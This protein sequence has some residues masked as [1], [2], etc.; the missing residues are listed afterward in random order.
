MVQCR[1]A[2]E[3][4]LLISG[5][6]HDGSCWHK[7]AVQLERAGHTV[8]APD[9][10]SYGLDR[11]APEAVTL[12]MWT[13]GICRLLDSHPGPVILVGHSRAGIVISQVAERLPGKIKVLVYVSGFLLRHGESVL[14]VLRDDGTSPLLRQATLAADKSG[15]RVTEEA[16]R[17]MFYGKCADADIALACSRLRPE[18]AA[19]LMTPIQVTEQ[20][21]GA[22]PRMYIECL[23]DRAIPLALQKKMQAASPCGRVLSLPTDHSPFFSAPERLAAQLLSCLR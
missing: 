13:Q 3:T 12:E 1:M 14:R 17:E 15:W 16:M 2:R 11:T 22:V 5:A 18:P 10:Q 4:F 6:W 9:L 19:P 21:F 20:N 23:D 8:V 7:T